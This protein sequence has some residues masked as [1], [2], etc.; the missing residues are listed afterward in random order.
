MSK[1][2]VTGSV[3]VPFTAREEALTLAWERY[4]EWC[5]WMGAATRPDALVVDMRRV[6]RLERLVHEASVAAHRLGVPEQLRPSCSEL[7]MAPVHARLKAADA[8]AV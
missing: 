4:S 6:V 7:R 1:H 3:S 8:A 2:A 5:A